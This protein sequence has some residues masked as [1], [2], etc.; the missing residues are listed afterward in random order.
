MPNRIK[1]YEPLDTRDFV[2]FSGYMFDKKLAIA[3]SEVMGKKLEI[4]PYQRVNF[5]I[6]RQLCSMICLQNDLQ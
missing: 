1:M 3:A 5:G 2:D 4:L 6:D